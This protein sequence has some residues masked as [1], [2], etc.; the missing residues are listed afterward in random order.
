MGQRM[1]V[2]KDTNVSNASRGSKILASQHM[3]PEMALGVGRL[4]AN[5]T[6]HTPFTD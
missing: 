4:R 3:P 6:Y 5:H 1:R 2:A